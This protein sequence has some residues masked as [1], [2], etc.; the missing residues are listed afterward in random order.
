MGAPPIHDARTEDRVDIAY[1]ML[2]AATL[3]ALGDPVTLSVANSAAGSQL[4]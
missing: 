2:G 1:W 3:E 4:G